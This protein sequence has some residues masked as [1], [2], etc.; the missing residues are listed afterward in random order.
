MLCQGARC[1][2]DL[3]P[4]HGRYQF[5]YFSGIDIKPA[6][7]VRGNA[8]GAVSDGALI[9]AAK[10]EKPIVLILDEWDKGAQELDA[11]LLDFLQSR[12]IRDMNG[13][14][15]YI[16]DSEVWVFLTSNGDRDI[17]DALSRRVRKWEIAKLPAAQVAKILEVETD[18]QLLTLCSLDM[19]INHARRACTGRLFLFFL[20]D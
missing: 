8:N 4:D 20:S 17:S 2:S 18:N 14:M 19:L 3:L 7:V 1:G 5:L 16:P 15:R 11:F 13:E 6:E 9:K 12:R 10:A